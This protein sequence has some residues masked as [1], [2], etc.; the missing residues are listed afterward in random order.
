MS[1]LFVKPIF[2]KNNKQIN[3]SI[4]KRQLSPELRKKLNNKTFLKSKMRIKLYD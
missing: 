1:K 2:N 4:P 3:F